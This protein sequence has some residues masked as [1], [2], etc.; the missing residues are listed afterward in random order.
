MRSHREESLLPVWYACPKSYGGGEQAGWIANPTPP[1]AY[2][3]NG[4]ELNVDFGLNLN[5]YGARWYDP[6]VGRFT[7]IDPLTEKMTRWSGYNYGFNNPMR[8]IDPDGMESKPFNEYLTVNNADGSQTTRQISNK[9][10]DNYDIVHSTN[11]LPITAVGFSGS[12]TV[13]ENTEG[14]Q[15][16]APGVFADRPA[17][18]ALESVDDPVTAIEKGGATMA[19][20]LFVGVLKNTGKEV[21]KEGA[22]AAT[23]SETKAALKEVYKKLDVDG[24]LPKIEKGKFGSPQRSDGLKGYRLDPGHPDRPAGHSESGPHINYWDKTNGTKRNKGL[25]EDVVP[26][27]NLRMENQ[28]NGNGVTLDQSRN[29]FS[30]IQNYLTSK[31]RFDADVFKDTATFY[32]SVQEKLI[33]NIEMTNDV[34]L[35]YVIDKIGINEIR[36]SDPIFVIKELPHEIEKLSYREL[37]LNWDRYWGIPEIDA[38]IF[39]IPNGKTVLLTHWN[40]LYF[41]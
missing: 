5:D 29:N 30:E 11:G 33:N 2:K 17:S 14:G 26:I 37:N 6:G 39:Q 10:G 38:L 18:G 22:E 7:S 13:T 3:Y 27:K 8:F 23:I 40:V 1:N 41:D 12:T 19:M 9:G 34:N 20:G 28:I 15:R 32:K 31:F 35:M 16:L 36:L 21:V 24:P 4:K 25:I